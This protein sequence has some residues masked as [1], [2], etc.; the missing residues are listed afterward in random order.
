M[1]YEHECS[2]RSS[3]A[4]G[5]QGET[6]AGYMGGNADNFLAQYD[7]NENRSTITQEDN[8]MQKVY[9]PAEEIKLE[10]PSPY[11]SRYTILQ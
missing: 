9:S 2:G 7:T 10:R 5:A 11:L 3:S 6:L 8:P 4:F 1:V